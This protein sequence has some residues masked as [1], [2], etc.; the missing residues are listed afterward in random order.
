MNTPKVHILDNYKSF[1]G[2]RRWTRWIPHTD[3]K[4]LQAAATR[5]VL[6]LTC[7]KSYNRQQRAYWETVYMVGSSD[8]A[9]KAAAV[10][11]RM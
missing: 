11:R 1:C 9:A 2:V 10:L 4:N 5:R 8:Q 7:A 6:C 3:H